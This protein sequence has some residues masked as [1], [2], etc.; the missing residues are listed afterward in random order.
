MKNLIHL[1]RRNPATQKILLTMRLTLLLL[2]ISVFSA[3][4]SSYAQ[5]T[6]LDINVQNSSVKDVLDAIENKSEFFF[7]YNNKQVDVERKVDL[8]AESSTVDVVL[9]KLFAGTEVNFKVVNRQILLFPNDIINFA[10]QQERKISGKVTDASGTPLPGASVV[11]KGTTTGMITDNSGNFSINI[12]ENAILQFS[13]VG[14]KSLEINVGNRET[15]NMALTEEV[16]GLEEVV[17]IG[18][19]TQKKVSLTGAI[20][21]ITSDKLEL[22]PTSNLSNTLAGR[23]PGVTISSNSGFVGATSDILIRGKGTYN[24][25]T[26]LYVIDGIISDKTSFDVLDPN[27]VD[28]ISF[29]K[30]ASSASIYGSR[31]ASGVVLVMTKKGKVQK[32]VFRYQVSTSTERPTRPLQSYTASDQIKY[33]NDVAITYG[34]PVP[35]SQEVIDYF[36][37]KSYSLLDYIW[38]NP[39]SQQHDLSVNGGTENLTYYMMVGYNKNLGS[40]YNCDYSRYNFRSNVTAKINKY[41]SVNLNLSGNQREGNRFYW[42][43]DDPE[44]TT[45]QDF[46]RATFNWQ[47]LWPFY[48]DKSGNATNDRSVGYPVGVEGWHPIELVYNGGYRK[49]VYRTLNSIIRIDLKIPYIDGLST[50]FQANYT[51]NDYNGKN[52]VKFNKQYAFQRASTTNPYVPAPINPINENVMNLS[53]SYEGIDEN[54]TFSNSYQLNWFLN[55]DK[56]FGKHAISGM[57]VYE[58]QGTKGKNFGGQANQLLSSSI[59]QIF[60]TSVSADKRYFDG[61]EH[62]YARASWIGRLHYEYAGKYIAEF[63]GRYDGSYIFPENTRW[64]FFPSGSVGWRINKESF[65]DVPAISNLK[66]RGSIGNSGNDNVSAFQFQNN[67]VIGNSYAFG[68]GINTGIQPGTPP[69]PYITWEK[70]TNFNVGIDFGLFNN[71][72]TGDVDYFY[73]YSYDILKERTRVIPATYGANL[74]SENYAK[75]DVRGFEF[76]LNYNGK[77]GNFN[78][79]VGGNMGW[80]KDK[81]LAIDEPAGME[82]WRSAIGHPMD[83]IW[84]YDDFGIL[85]TQNQLDA[86]PAG[87]TQWGS[88]PQLGAILYK[89]IRGANRS[90]GADG[91]IDANDMTFLSDNAIPRIN[92]GINL[93]GE[94]KGITLNLLFQGVGAYD[95]ILSTKDTPNGGVFQGGQRP[96]FEIWTQHWTP[97]TPNAPYPRAATYSWNPYGIYGSKFWIR[98]GAYLRL[99]NINLAY[100]LPKSWT[101]HILVNNCQVYLNATDLFCISGV[102][103]TDPEQYMMDSYPI[104]KSF[105]AGLKITF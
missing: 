88:K 66:L 1:Y 40:F 70:S 97:E 27:E 41:L 45:L 102:S 38:R 16:V 48:V 20:T 60:A 31:A 64:G 90:P 61:S 101:N 51:A 76:S 10:E 78:Y 33:Q 11:V 72:L 29:L 81:V 83:R 34:N 19:G 100:T 3:F 37:D 84:G 44:S 93:D 65:F 58:Q 28:N 21:N 14:M 53:R 42:P 52:F 59:D 8:M 63:S 103:E 79:T 17:T 69:N 95:K 89:D 67:Y 47:K 7:M 30:D 57:L 105:T 82:A 104:M 9:G 2:V 87:F 99:K 68:N 4:S 36:K 55:Y 71:K 32:P 6:K 85:R 98:N 94:W 39:T 56:I 43:Y 49:M 18:Y 35:N 62:E 22:I 92:Y 23:V 77:I 15:I 96:Y 13:F 25:T 5:K 86:L 74:S 80:A 91:N 50:S 75:M 54:A 12:P 46:Y 26:P 24:N 73:R